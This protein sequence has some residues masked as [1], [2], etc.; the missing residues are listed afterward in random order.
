[1]HSTRPTEPSSAELGPTQLNVNH[2]LNVN[3]ATPHH[4][5]SI[6]LHNNMS[7]RFGTYA[8]IEERIEI[9]IAELDSGIHANMRA[10]A[11]YNH[12]PYSRLQKRVSGRA[13]KIER[14]APNRRLNQQQEDAL[15]AYI[16]RCDA[17]YMPPLIPQLI[18][19]AQRILDLEHP[20]GKAPPIDKN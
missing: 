19:A 4:F 3:F 18:S 16:T 1:M 2:Q 15:K 14:A 6:F 5:D 13:S 20:D 12:M 7:Q 10:A 17:L 8:Q 9:T 11:D